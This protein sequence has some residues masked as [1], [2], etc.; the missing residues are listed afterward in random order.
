MS[1]DTPG[2]VAAARPPLGTRG[3]A[4]MG[5]PTATTAPSR[6]HPPG[7]IRMPP[8]GCAIC[9]TITC[10]GEFMVSCGGRCNGCIY[11]NY[12]NARHSVVRL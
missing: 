8:S 7:R 5:P 1:P 10:S 4:G 2:E 6:I 12:D 9:A 11:W 3:C